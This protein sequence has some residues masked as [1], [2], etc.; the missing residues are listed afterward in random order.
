MLVP[1]VITSGLLAAFNRQAE[2]V[3]GFRVGKSNTVNKLTIVYRK[4]D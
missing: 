4:S 3:F 2:A 1:Q